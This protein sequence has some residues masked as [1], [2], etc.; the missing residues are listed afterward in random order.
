MDILFVAGF[1]PIASD[2]HTGRHFYMDALG[3]GLEADGDYLHTSGLE[4]VKHFAVWPLSLAARS[5]FD[6]DAW[7]EGTPAP[8]AWIEFDVRDLAEATR[9][10]RASGHHLL[11]AER[12][13]PWGQRVTRL[14]SPEGLLVGLTVTPAQR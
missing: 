2:I 6:A 3:I 11:V 12:E 9:E 14:L 1:G 10:L 4:G 8:H 5:C 7:P 13:E